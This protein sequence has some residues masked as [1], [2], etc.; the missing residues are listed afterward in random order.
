MPTQI[1]VAFVCGRAGSAF[2]DTVS[3]PMIPYGVKNKST[4]S[5]APGVA[6]ETHG[7]QNGRGIGP[8]GETLYLISSQAPPQR[9]GSARDTSLADTPGRA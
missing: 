6:L 1:I 9:H 4:R 2:F 5:N 7:Y 8:L 3:K